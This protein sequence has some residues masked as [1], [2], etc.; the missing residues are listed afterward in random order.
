M[1]NL[2]M[3]GVDVM[4]IP[5]AR[6]TGLFQLAI[7]RF[8]ISIFIQHKC[9]KQDSGESRAKKVTTLKPKPSS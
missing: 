7:T 1:S 3:Q 9:E 5:I 2:L 4:G 8:L 6:H